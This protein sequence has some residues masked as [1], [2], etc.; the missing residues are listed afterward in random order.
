MPKYRLI[1][2]QYFVVGSGSPIKWSTPQTWSDTVKTR[3]EPG[4]QDGEKFPTKGQ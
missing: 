4:L 2:I 1:R 3:Q